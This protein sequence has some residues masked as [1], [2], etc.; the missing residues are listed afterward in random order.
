M[1]QTDLETYT[2]VSMSKEQATDLPGCIFILRMEKFA[3]KVNCQLIECRGFYKDTLRM[4]DKK[5]G[6]IQE[7]P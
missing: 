5:W 4:L 6:Y 2:A 3:Q 1:L 7:P